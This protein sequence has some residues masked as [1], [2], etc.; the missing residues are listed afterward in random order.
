M[1]AFIFHRPGEKN[2]VIELAR[3][4]GIWGH[5]AWEKCIAP[6]F[7]APEVSA[8]VVANLLFGIFESDGYVSREQTG[9]LRLG[10]TTTS[11]Q[12]AHQ[13]HWLLLRWGIGSG[14][15]QY[16]P[17]SQRPSIIKG[18]KVQSKRDIWEVRVSGIDNVERFAAALPSCG[19]RTSALAKALQDPELSKHRGSQRGYLPENQ[20]EP[21]LAYLHGLGISPTFAAQVIGRD[22]GDPQGGLRQVLGHSR[23]RR[24]RV[25]R[26]ADAIDSEFLRQVLDE[27]VWYDKV[28]AISPEEWRATYD[29]GVEELHSF[30]TNDVVVHN[31]APPFT[32]SEFD[33]MYG[34]G[35]SREGSVLDIGVDL[36]FVKKS[37]AW[38]TYEG[39]QLGQGRENAKEFLRS[40]PE[41]MVEVSEK[42]RSAKGLGDQPEEEAPAEVEDFS[43]ADDE[44]IKLDD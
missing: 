15:R 14:V 20:T 30:V 36:G 33:I 16:D 29:L 21:V 8:E 28:V 44:P 41:I 32:Q 13:I 38:Y 27:D 24:D 1:E 26:L 9:G 39:E 23:L 6:A 11:E 7:F 34:H 17:T 12:L 22:A 10:F 5:L 42:I 25:E 37:G 2:G 43:E 31:C 35:I 40:N 3:W 19:P 4:A 18:R